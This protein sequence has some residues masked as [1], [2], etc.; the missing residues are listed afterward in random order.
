LD[1]PSEKSI[2]NPQ[3]APAETLMTALI[4]DISASSAGDQRVI[5]LDDYYVI[6]DKPIDDTLTFLLD[7]LPPL[8]EGMQ[9]VIATRDDPDLPP[10]RLRPRGQLTELR[11]TDL[12]F[13][14]SEAAEFLSKVMGLDLSAESRLFATRVWWDSTQFSKEVGTKKLVIF[15]FF[16]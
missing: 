2:Q 14:S 10:A 7:H 1:S 12:C 9:P 13:T 5:V 8:P 4:N 15:W 16:D 11:A 3:S 6:K